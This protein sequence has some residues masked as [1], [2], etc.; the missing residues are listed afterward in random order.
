MLSSLSDGHYVRQI[1]QRIPRR[2]GHNTHNNWFLVK[3]AV[4]E[5]RSLCIAQSTSR[6]PGVARDLERA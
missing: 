5:I 1:H 2:V 6:E 3:E 4:L